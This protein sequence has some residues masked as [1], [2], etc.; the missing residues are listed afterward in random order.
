MTSPLTLLV[1]PSS[2]EN[3]PEILSLS[4]AS[5]EY[6]IKCRSH[7]CKRSRGHASTT[8]TTYPRLMN[9][10]SFPTWCARA[11]SQACH[12]P[13]KSTRSWAART[14]QVS[15]QLLKSQPGSNS[16]KHTGMA[17]MH[18]RIRE[19]VSRSQLPVEPLCLRDE[20][21]NSN[22]TNHTFLNI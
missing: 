6:L 19:P 20:K 12:Q 16:P 5:K 11:K 7:Y 13:S 1:V 9:L 2:M 8:R 18:K 17:G 22:F 3:S 21:F 14:N 4:P 10:S 15:Q